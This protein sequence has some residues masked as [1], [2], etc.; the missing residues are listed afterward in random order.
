MLILL[1]ALGMSVCCGRGQTQQDVKKEWKSC[2]MLVSFVFPHK[3]LC[4]C[5]NWEALVGGLSGSGSAS[6]G[7]QGRPTLSPPEPGEWQAALWGRTPHLVSA[8]HGWASYALRMLQVIT[9]K[10]VLFFNDCCAANPTDWLW[11]EGY[12]C[13]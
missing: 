10:A 5:L 8:R 11:H 13:Y 12:C 3:S 2:L 1:Q 6:L 4:G 7:I 9:R